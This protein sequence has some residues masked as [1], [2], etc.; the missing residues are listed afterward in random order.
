MLSSEFALNFI[1]IKGEKYSA[2]YIP[3][4]ANMKPKWKFWIS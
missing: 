3:H 4:E 2:D 1:Q